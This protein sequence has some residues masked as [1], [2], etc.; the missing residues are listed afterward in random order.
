MQLPAFAGRQAPAEIRLRESGAGEK[1]EGE[2]GA[3]APNRK[4][5][6]ERVSQAGTHLNLVNN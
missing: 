6:A 5:G 1:Q 2:W 3:S 4:R